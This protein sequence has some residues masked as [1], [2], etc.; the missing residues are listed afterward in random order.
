[1][2][3]DSGV[4]YPPG[5]PARKT[6]TGPGGKG[7]TRGKKKTVEPS[8]R[9]LTPVQAAGGTAPSSVT[10]LQT[11]I[12]EDG[13][14][15]LRAF[16]DPLGGRWQILAALP[17]ESVKP[18]PYQRDLSEAHVTRLSDRIDRLDRFLDPII[19]YRAGAREFWTPNGHHR[20]AAMRR[21]GAR[22]VTALVLADREIAYKILALNTEKAHN[23]REKSLEVIRMARA[24]SGLD[25]RPEK[26]FAVEF[27][28]PAFLTL[29]ICYEKQGRFSGGAYQPILKRVE[30]FLAAALPDALATRE[31]RAQ[32]L[33]ELDAAV[34][35]VVT[36]LRDRGLDSPYLKAFVLARINP[37]RFERGATASFDE[38]IDKMHA[39][40]GRF[41][42][43]KIKADQIARAA[44]P[45]G[46]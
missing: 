24:L 39:S 30:K 18:T 35:E 32:K 11:Q 10:Q 31:A 37:L 14:S 40:A 41:D 17:I 6:E 29:G 15:V 5:M 38:V 25:P 2:S 19:A 8:S 9:G 44:G 28:E 20:L 36:R 1:M 12:E 16:K 45:P 46:D 23:V 27:E 7:R 33:L 22:T 42:P 26:E 3:F 13:G 4:A 43:G 34:A 21:L